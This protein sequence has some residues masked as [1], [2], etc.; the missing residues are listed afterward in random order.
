MKEEDPEQKEQSPL[1]GYGESPEGP[2]GDARSLMYELK[3]HQ[4]ELKTQNEELQEAQIELARARDRYKELFDSAPI[5]YLVLDGIRTI[6]EANHTASSLLGIPRKDLIGAHFSRFMDREAADIYHVHMTEVLDKGTQQSRE[7]VFRR[8]DG[9]L[10]HGHLET[11]PYEDSL[12]GNG[13]R[14]AL[15]DI[16]E[17][18]R[19]EQAVRDSEER[20]RFALEAS[21]T[22]AWDLDLG[23][24]TAFRSL[25]HDRIFG[26]TEILPQWTY[27]MFL[28]HVLTEDRNEV[29]AKFRHAI[30]TKSDW[31]FECRIRRTDGEV[32]WIWAAG[33]HIADV[34]GT[35]RR[36]A[37]IVQDI[38]ERKQAEEA[39]RK[40]KDELEER[41]KERTY[42]LYTESLYARSLIEASMDPLVTISIDGKI[43]DVN[44]ATEDAT[45]VSREQ[46]IGSDFSDY[47]TEPEK[48]RAGYKEV[49][50]QGLVRDY[51]LELKHRD[52]QVTPVHYNATLY[53]DET[54][55]IMGVFAAAR[56][57]TERKQAEAALRRLAS[58]LVM[59]E[60]RERKRIAGVLHDDIAQI[61][62]A[63]RM[64]L[65]LLQG[66]P[67]DQRD[68]QVLKEA[69]SFLL[70]T[71]QETRALMNDL[72]N[73]VLFDLG[74]KSACEALAD[75]LMEKSHV[76]I[77][78]DIRD[79]YKDLNP[80]VKILLYQVV[81]ELLNNVVKHSQAKNAQL[82]ISMDKGHFRVQV[83]DD[84]VG[85]D[86]QT[87][88]KPTVEGGYG[89]YSIRERLIAIEGSLRIES[90]PGNGTTVTASLPETLD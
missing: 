12:Y 7:L 14:I 86:P 53:R 85:F 52:G 18:K 4:E 76:R 10:F 40:A 23:D 19:A 39:L 35:L 80:D 73:P 69:K 83:R 77:R 26:Y 78:C 41:V 46:L 64:R 65:D 31:S 22:G 50:Q 48:A 82:L 44:R 62:A 3:V 66:V 38:T 28:N 89:L 49:F 5:G 27:A 59:A 33:R 72:G 36:L 13:W 54:G 60:E 70:Q 16:T 58:E 42:E 68:N 8:P 84:G 56:D 51:P 37:G 88:G 75:R 21:H 61:L 71:I 34:T 87:L 79:A 32:R 24:H 15:V 57:I 74:L 17:R 47:F 43:T 81:R 11:S 20:Q 9:S 63:I 25:E 2:P 1:N 45:G 6:R 55:K 30:E 67:S 29:D 90:S